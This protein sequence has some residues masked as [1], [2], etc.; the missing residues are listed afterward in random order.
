MKPGR[1]GAYCTQHQVLG[2]HR[3]LF[4]H[5]PFQTSISRIVLRN[6]VVACRQYEYNSPGTIVAYLLYRYI[7]R[8]NVMQRTFQ[9]S[10]PPQASSA[11]NVNFHSLI[12][13]SL[14]NPK[15]SHLTL[16]P[17]TAQMP[18]DGL[19]RIQKAID[20][21]LHARCLRARELT[22]ADFACD[23]FLPAHVCET[24]DRWEQNTKISSA[25]CSTGLW[26]V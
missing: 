20:A 11:S 13:A 5:D 21:I 12:F 10:K 26:L 9:A 4:V 23:A 7:H 19:V 25:D 18:Q 6:A 8:S 2:Y 15:R 17:H 16:A 14:L 24:V 22:L 3:A 1:S